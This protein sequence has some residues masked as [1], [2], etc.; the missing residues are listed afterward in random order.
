MKMETYTLSQVLRNP[1]KADGCV[2]SDARLLVI[3]STRQKLEQ[4]PI[5]NSITE[6]VND[7]QDS[8]DRLL[9]DYGGNIGETGRL[10]IVRPKREIN[11]SLY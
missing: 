2:G 5:H 11:N 9:A 1:A 3:S 6:F 10:E 4:F 8:L 7:R